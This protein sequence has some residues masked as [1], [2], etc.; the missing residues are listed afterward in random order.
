MRHPISLLGSFDLNYVKVGKCGVDKKP[1]VTVYVT[2]YNYGRYI[3]EALE[4]VF[5]QGYENFELIIIDDGSTD[6][7]QDIISRY[8]EREKVHIVLQKN[9]G[10]TV[11]NNVALRLS[12]GKY[13]MRLDADDYLEPSALSV[14]VEALEN[15]DSIALVF[16]DYFEVDEHGHM[17]QHVQ[18]HDFSLKVSLYDQPAHGAC[19]MIRT[20]ALRAVGGYDET[21]TRQ[22]GYDLWLK[23]I[24]Q[25]TVR[26]VN[27]PLFYYRQHSK[28]LTKDEK[29]LLE[30]R[31]SIIKKH[32]EKKCG[33]Q[34]PSVLAVIPVRGSAVDA[35]S[36][37]LQSLGG[38]C[39]ID[40]TI[41]AALSS[42]EI[43]DVLVTTSEQRVLDH[44]V[45]RYS[46]RVICHER[47]LEAS[48][49][50]VQ[51]IKTLEEVLAYFTAQG[52]QEP[53]NL[54]VLN[55]ESPF[56]NEMYINKAIHVKQLYDVDVVFGVRVDDDLFYT[57]DG[58]GLKPRTLDGFRLERDDLHRRVGG[59]TL[60]D[61]SF[62]KKNKNIIDGKIGHIHLDQR[63]AFAIKSEL[64]W[65]IAASL[66][67][68]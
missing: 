47:S 34:T 68:Q 11:T 42:G 39:L 7:S 55:I 41:D 53:E 33:K 5:A 17:L 44:V 20:K 59:I 18:R 22:D 38:R 54:M 12:N 62:F 28:S 63:A 48:R 27:K 1:L 6:N 23:V 40:W 30:T 31:S 49:I 66:A 52:N 58:S 24:H 37:P 51:I 61:T 14:L 35:R 45:S 3:E 29:A 60:V 2:N 25:Y 4:S 13:I 10:L 15:D 9:K 16:P 8:E 67:S 36:L 50:N 64:D 46:G 21:F 43:A 65:V 26:N 57:H 32:V 56:R 19:T